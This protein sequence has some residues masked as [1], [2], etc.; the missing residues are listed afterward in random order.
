M[1]WT[2]YDSKWKY[3]LNCLSGYCGGG[4]DDSNEY[5]SFQH[6]T[7]CLGEYE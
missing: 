6:L 4:Y 2:P 1:A 7:S 3:Y 5:H